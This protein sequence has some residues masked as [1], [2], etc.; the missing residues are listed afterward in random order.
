[1]ED[2]AGAWFTRQTPRWRDCQ[3]RSTCPGQAVSGSADLVHSVI[4]GYDFSASARNALAYAA[5]MA[6]QLKRPLLVVYVISVGISSEIITGH[7]ELP[8][9]ARDLEQRLLLEIDQVIGTCEF[10]VHVRA[11]HGSP[12]RELAVMVAE[13]RADALVIGAPA[14]I[15]HRFAGSVPGRLARD[16]RCPV[17]VVP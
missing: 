4:V 1:M 16:A 14:R 7:V 9:D 6:R 5:G 15:W 17:V 10:A 11:R 3:N 12:A 2:R 8:Y 13:L